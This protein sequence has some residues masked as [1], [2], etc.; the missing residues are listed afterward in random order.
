MFILKPHNLSFSEKAKCS[1]GWIRGD[2]KIKTLKS[3]TEGCIYFPSL[4]FTMLT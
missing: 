1:L 2:V 3:T 4:I